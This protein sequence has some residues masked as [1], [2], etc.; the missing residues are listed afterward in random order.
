MLCNPIFGNLHF[1]LK[2]KLHVRQFK[3]KNK[4]QKIKKEVKNIYTLI[5]FRTRQNTTEH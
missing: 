4:E 5:I 1:Y 2:K 3:V